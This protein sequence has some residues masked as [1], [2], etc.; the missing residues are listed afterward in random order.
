M[1]S[2]QVPKILELWHEGIL[3]AWLFGELHVIGSRS[4]ETIP[5]ISHSMRMGVYSD[6]KD[7]RSSHQTIQ[8]EARMTAV[9]KEWA[10]DLRES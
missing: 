8:G 7:F 10:K 3:D 5:S 9:G 1:A 4:L 2:A 6:G